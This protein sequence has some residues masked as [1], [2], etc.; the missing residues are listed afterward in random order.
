[1]EP[2]A[3]RDMLVANTKKKRGVDLVLPKKDDVCT[4]VSA[5]AYLDDFVVCLKE[6]QPDGQRV[7]A[8]YVAPV[9]TEGG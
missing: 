8:V 7:P 5:S 9:E 6:V 1:V 3:V 2:D 4:V